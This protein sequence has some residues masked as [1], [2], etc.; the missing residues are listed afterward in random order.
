MHSRSCNEPINHNFLVIKDKNAINISIPINSLG[1]LGF[2][3]EK[4]HF[5]S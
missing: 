4:V 3:I 1:V 2:N 5:V